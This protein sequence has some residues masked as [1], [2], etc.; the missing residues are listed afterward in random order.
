MIFC[1]YGC[2]KE[3]R[4]QFKNGNWCCEDSHNKCLNIRKKN[5]KSSSRR[6]RPKHSSESK[7]KM[8]NSHKG[9]ILLEEHKKK[10]GIAN[11]GKIF[12]KEHRIKISESQKDK[13]NSMYGKTPSNKLTIKKI[14]KKYPFFSQIEEMRY[15]PYKPKEIQVR[16]KNHLCENSK[17]MNGWFTPTYIQISMRI[18]QL[19][20]KYG[21]GGGYFYCSQDCKNICPLFN[22]RS[23]PFKET[24]KLYT[25]EEY[26]QFREFVLR[27]DKYECQYC[28]EA[29]IDVHHERPQKLEPL[30]VLDPDFAWSCCEECHYKY[31][32]KT[33]TECSTGNL[34]NLQCN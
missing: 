34:G 14:N 30:F 20:S 24:K 31:G 25:Q 9:K 16:C 7:R 12:S 21:N 15:N 2:G 13:R 33:G 17:E 22:L 23:D 5:S 28:E 1:E 3:A 26:Q 29:A 8:S 4:Y 18:Q 11:K 6:L 32:H 19:E 10:I 27:R